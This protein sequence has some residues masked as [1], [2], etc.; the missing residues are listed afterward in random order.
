MI[1]DINISEKSFGDKILMTNVKFSI[2]DG[3]K[4]GIVGRKW[5]YKSTLFNILSEAI[6]IFSEKLFFGV[7]VKARREEHHNLADMLVDY[8]LNGLPEYKVAASKIINEYP[9]FR[10]QYTFNQRI[11]RSTG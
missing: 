4:I 11:F 5:N 2:D 9:S 8:I 6:K 7:S 1:A 3:E 10:R